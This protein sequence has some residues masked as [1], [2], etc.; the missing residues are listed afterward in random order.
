MEI[1]LRDVGENQDEEA[2]EELRSFIENLVAEGKADFII[3]LFE[4][5]YSCVPFHNY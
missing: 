1:V 5:N 3:K 2:I 4:G